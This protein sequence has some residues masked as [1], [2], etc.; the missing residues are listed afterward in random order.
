GSYRVEGSTRDRWYQF[1]RIARL[2]TAGHPPDVM[3]V[4]LGGNDIGCQTGKSLAQDIVH[5]LTAWKE[6]APEAKLVWSTIIPRCQ[7]KARCAAQ[8]MNKV[9]REINRDV[10]RAMVHGLG[11]VVGHPRIPAASAELYRDNGVHLSDRGMEIFL[12]DLK[13]GLLEVLSG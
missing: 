5:D 1:E 11:T 9:H 10:C 8:L 2:A 13:R 12:T 4:H 7:W 3:L 6:D